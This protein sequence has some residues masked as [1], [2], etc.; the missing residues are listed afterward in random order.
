MKKIC[1]YLVEFA[2]QH[3]CEHRRGT[4]QVR[5]DDSAEGAYDHPGICEA[6]ER[7]VLLMT[8]RRAQFRRR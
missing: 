5:H 8:T 2:W 7:L 3:L 1:G 4:G 6:L